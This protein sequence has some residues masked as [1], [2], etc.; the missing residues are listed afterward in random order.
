MMMDV[1]DLKEASDTT[2]EGLPSYKPAVPNSASDKKLAPV[3][4]SG[5]NPK[6]SRIPSKQARLSQL[7]LEIQE[8]LVRRVNLS[9]LASE[10]ENDSGMRDEVRRQIGFIIKD[11]IRKGRITESEGF[12]AEK[13]AF[14]DILGYGPLQD[15]LDDPAISEIMVVAPDQIYSEQSGKLLLTDRAFLSDEHA[16]QVLRRLLRASGRPINEANP[17]VNA[18][19]EDGSRLN[20]VLPPIA[21]KGATI[22]IRKFHRNLSVQQLIDYGTLNKGMATFL[23]LAV[24]ARMNIVVSGGTGSGK[25]TLLNVL[26]SFIPEDQR[27][28]TVEDTAELALMQAHVVRLQSRPKNSEGV[29]GISI[30]EL[31]IESLRMRPDR[32]IVG[33]CRSA[34]ALDML[35]AMNTGHDGSLTTVHANTAADALHRLET[36]VLYSGMDLPMRAIMEQIRSAV[37]LVVQQSRMVDGKRKI[38]EIVEV[39]SIEDEQIRV[40]PIFKFEMEKMDSTG[41]VGRHYWAGHTPAFIHKLKMRGIEVPAEIFAS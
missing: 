1:S 18:T 35:Q 5:A 8:T 24:E 30:R 38:T 15:L 19:L 31:V 33:E 3:A 6:S 23:R 12:Q 27:I 21:L 10:A 25:T 2:G 13:K 39:T 29:G 11:L 32:I 9:K 14:E 40:Q 22:T 17:I 4:A 28:V 36:M 37:N 41:V 20:A 26:S 7:S 16:R 34:E